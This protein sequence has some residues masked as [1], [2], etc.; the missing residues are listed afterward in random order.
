MTQDWSQG[1]V[2]R[3]GA[4]VRRLRTSSRPTLSAQALSDRTTEL[5]HPISRA[6]ISDLETGRRRGLDVSDL[7]ILAAAL[8][9]A[10]AQLLFP[11]LPRGRF[12]VLPGVEQEAHDAVRWF[13]GEV[14]LLMESDGWSDDS[15][16]AVQMV[17]RQEFDPELDRIALMREWLRAVTSMR[18]ARMLLQKALT[19]NESQEQ[20]AA[21]EFVYENALAQSTTLTERMRELGMEV[22]NGHAR[23]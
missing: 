8:R 3:V 21:L 12:D 16:N 20:I 6:V 23:A 9:V 11:D 10:P 17:A 4:E 2:D 15:D 7:L 22:G 14:G 5:G 1:A 19:D 18:S 13:G